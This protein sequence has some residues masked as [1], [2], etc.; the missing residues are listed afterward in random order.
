MSRSPARG[1]QYITPTRVSGLL[2][3]K[4]APRLAPRGARAIAYLRVSTEKQVDSGLGLKA[5]RASVTAAAARLHLPLG[6]V[7][8]DAG[9]SARSPRPIARS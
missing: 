2:V 6:A 3:M 8:T 1:Q 7:F 9:M 5:Q 4:A